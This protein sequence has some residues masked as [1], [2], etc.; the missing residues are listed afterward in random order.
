MRRATH[1]SAA[2]KYFQELDAD[3][4]LLQEVRSIPDDVS[5]GFTALLHNASTKTGTKQRF[6]TAVL[7]RGQA[8][9][10]LVLESE[11]SWVNEE[12]DRLAGNFVGCD[13]TIKDATLR[14]LSVHS[15]AWPIDRQRL[16]GIDVSSIKLEN[17]PDVW[18]TEL[19]W[20][21]L[22][23]AD[24]T[25]PWIV[26]GDLNS[27]ETFDYMWSGGPHGNR[28]VLDRVQDLGF[29]ELLR[30]SQGALTPTF[31]NPRD[32]KV[33]HQIDHLFVS[34]ELLRTLVRCDVGSADRVFGGGLSDHLPII[35]DLAD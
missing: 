1:T 30:H 22:K 31:R 32:K 27:S 20:A 3:L 14:V 28:E 19:L 17:N 16:A 5:Q 13:V 9:E 26:G 25:L 18:G 6:K 8:S 24:R 15:P 29:T 23:H 12:L 7:V 11:S 34:K 33:V 21:A 4:A 35:A 10:R 2:W